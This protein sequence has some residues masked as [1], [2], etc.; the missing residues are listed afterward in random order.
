MGTLGE[1]LGS[2]S[3]V[4][5]LLL[6]LNGN[7]TDTSGNSNSGTDT[8]ITYSQANGRFGQG[9]GFNNTPSSY[10]AFGNV[11][12]FDYNTAFTISAWLQNNQTANCN[13]ISK[14]ENSGNY[15]G[16]GL[17]VNSVG[18]KLQFFLYR[19]TSSLIV[20]FPDDY[21]DKVYQIGVTYDGSNTQ[22]GIKL[23][24][25][26]VEVTK[27]SVSNLPLSGSLASTAAFQISGRGGAANLWKGTIDEVVIENVAWSAEKFKKYYTYAKGRFGII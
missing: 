24:V 23:Y 16:Y 20:D 27:T 6:H 26:G 22:A 10:I 25:D 13:I 18:T 3:G 7:S 17:S 21:N 8:A 5:K 2:G 9:A 14:Q 19:D 11:L 12:Q 1:Y 15:Y 4:T